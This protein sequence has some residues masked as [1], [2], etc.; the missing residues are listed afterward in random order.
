MTVSFA[1]HSKIQNAQTLRSRLRE[2]L[3]KIIEENEII[4]FYCG[5]YGDFDL[6]CGRVLFELKK[7][8][9]PLQSFYIT[10]YL[11][12][13]PRLKDQAFLDLYDGVIYPPLEVTPPRF[14]ILKRNQWMIDNSDLLLAYV[15]YSFG[16]AAKTRAYAEKKG[17][18]VINI[19]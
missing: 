16:G 18:P 7:E 15:I 13:D 14:A 5:G 2:I 11:V 6:L 8:G 9:L 10:P 4:T 1:G 19:E 17:K 3:C 12:G